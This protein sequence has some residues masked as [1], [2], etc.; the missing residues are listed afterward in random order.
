MLVDWCLV[1]AGQS[2]LGAAWCWVLGAGRWS[3]V[4]VCTQ[5]SR[6]GCSSGALACAAAG[7]ACTVLNTP[8]SFTLAKSPR[9]A[10]Q[11]TPHPR[12]HFPGCP[13]LPACLPAVSVVGAGNV[14]FSNCNMGVNFADNMG[15]AG[16][17]RWPSLVLLCMHC[18]MLQHGSELC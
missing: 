17:W 2:V 4:G 6:R 14:R 5:V 7:C 3:L 15:G 10:S 8:S 11:P 16:E 13:R 1:L 12:H 18:L 9:T